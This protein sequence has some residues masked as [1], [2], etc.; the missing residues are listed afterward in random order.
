MTRFAA[1][2]EGLD[3]PP[4]WHALADLFLAEGWQYES[5]SAEWVKGE[6]HPI[7]GAAEGYDDTERG[8]IAWNPEG[9]RAWLVHP[10]P[11]PTLDDLRARRVVGTPD[12]HHVEVDR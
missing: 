7:I 10:G 4:A 12:S 8:R 5:E 6:P 3:R 2:P 9:T 1:K 11:R